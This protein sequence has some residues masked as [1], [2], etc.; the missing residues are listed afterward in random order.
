MKISL[1]NIAI[2]ISIKRIFFECLH[3]KG[4]IELENQRQALNEELIND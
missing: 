4:G 3:F 2:T 1:E